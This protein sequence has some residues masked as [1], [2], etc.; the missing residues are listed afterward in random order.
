MACSKASKVLAGL[1]LL[2]SGQAQP[3]PA[4]TPEHGLRKAF[5]QFQKDFKKSYDSEAEKAARFLAFVENYNRVQEHN[6]KKGSP[7]TGLLKDS[8]PFEG[9]KSLGTHKYSG[10]AL[11]K[12]VDWTAKKAVTP[13]K[14][15]QQCGSCWAFSTTGAMEGA[16]AIATGKLVSLSEQQLVDCGGSTGNQGCNGGLMDNGFKY[17]EGVAVCTEE[18]YPY[19]AKTGICQASGS[20]CKPGVPK[21][22]IVGYKDVTSWASTSLLI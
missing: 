1:A 20:S 2:S 17:E 19:T 13:V 3:T 6:S 10:A 22:G 11:P 8:K 14:N 7:H 4:P 5:E 12:D 16:W 18:S 21:G 9:L 15:Q